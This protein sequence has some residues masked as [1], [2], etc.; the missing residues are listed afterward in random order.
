MPN[1][2][3][4]SLKCFPGSAAYSEATSQGS[5]S[6]ITLDFGVARVVKVEMVRLKVKRT[7][8]TAANFQPFITNTAG[9]TS[10][11]GIDQEFL[12]ASTAVATLFDPSV[13]GGFMETD[14]NGKLY[15]LLVPDAGADNTFRYKARFRIHE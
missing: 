2:T 9:V 11:G 5:T 15:L 3:C 4:D 10:S 14:A 1:P 7:A 6:V 13:S 8:G 12:G